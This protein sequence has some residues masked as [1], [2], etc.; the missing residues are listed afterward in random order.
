M[1]AGDR[2]SRNGSAPRRSYSGR[3][4]VIRFRTL[5]KFLFPLHWHRHDE[6]ITVVS[7]PFRLSINKRRSEHRGRVAR[8]HP[9]EGRITAPGTEQARMVEVSGIGPFESI[10]RRT[11]ILWRHEASLRT[12][13]ADPGNCSRRNRS[14]SCRSRS[15]RKSPNSR[16]PT[17]CTSSSLNATMRRW[18]PSTPT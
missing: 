11:L 8:R 17:A 3:H 6:H 15:K 4:Y 9:G 1:A 14:P 13:P 12:V 2:R 16:S 10:Y 7:G 5:A 18:F